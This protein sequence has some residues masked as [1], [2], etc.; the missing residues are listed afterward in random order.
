MYAAE[1]SVPIACIPIFGK[2]NPRL[3]SG[4]LC[5]RPLVVQI[6]RD[7]IA[8]FFAIRSWLGSSRLLLFETDAPGMSDLRPRR[9]RLVL[10]G[11]G[12]RST[13][14]VTTK[15]VPQYVNKL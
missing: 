1:V 5:N 10:P 11:F 9:M 8:L 14:S 2:C 13:S 4:A 7:P 15:G 6:F 12:V 3:P